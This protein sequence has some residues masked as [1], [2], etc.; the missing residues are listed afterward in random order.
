[1]Q[2]FGDSALGAIVSAFAAIGVFLHSCEPAGP[3]IYCR[4]LHQTYSRK[5]LRDLATSG[6]GDK[7]PDPMGRSAPAVLCL[8]RSGDEP[9][10]LLG[11][12]AAFNL[13]S[14]G[15]P[16]SRAYRA[17]GCK[18]LRRCAGFDRFCADD[19]KHAACPVP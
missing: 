2:S 5:D 8:A 17:E 19:L 15:G 6:I 16:D 12:R 10:E 9:F 14:N 4:E 3:S 7:A 18:V 1:M 11:A 13:S